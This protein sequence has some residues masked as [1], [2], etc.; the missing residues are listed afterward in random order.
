MKRQV[1]TAQALQSVHEILRRY[2]VVVVSS[3]HVS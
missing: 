3:F 1:K 2:T